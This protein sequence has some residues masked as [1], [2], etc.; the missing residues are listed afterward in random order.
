MSPSDVHPQDTH[1]GD[2][3]GARVTTVRIVGINDVYSLAEL[4][5]LATLIARARETAPADRLL[6]TVAGDFLAPSLLSSLDG[7]RGMVACLNAL[8]VTHVTIG[9]H[10]DDLGFSDLC[11]RLDELKATVLVANAP[12]FAG[13]HVRSEVIEV[14]GVKVG[15][16]GVVEGDPSLFRKPPFGGAALLPTSGAVRE[17]AAHLR[18]AGCDAVIAL[19]HQRL[20]TD[21]ALAELGL[22]DLI[23]GGH[24]HE[25]YLETV[26]GIPLVKA[27]MNATAAIVADLAF[28]PGMPLR[29]AVRLEPVAGYPEDPAMRERVDALLVPVQRLEERVLLTLPEGVVLS[30][31]GSRHRE[32]SIGTLVCSRLRDALGAETALF[33]GGGLRGTVEHRGAFSYADLREEIPFDNETVVAHLPGAV[34]RDAIAY[35]RR[36]LRTSGGLSPRRRSGAGR[37]RRRAHRDRR[38]AAPSATHLFRG[39]GARPLVGHGPHHSA[40]GLRAGPPRGGARALLGDGDEGGALVGLRGIPGAMKRIGQER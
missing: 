39:A 23:L 12:D 33:N 22:V 5:R 11:A 27:P 8:G 19:T 18:S 24:E 2:T 17:E 31:A 4:P 9:N 34:L 16:L 14:R 3:A 15:L 10:E 6:V 38:R 36:E 7:G 37:C 29:L 20:S 21:R 1:R 30:S 26:N 35:A 25:G 40:R 13:R 32:T 28:T